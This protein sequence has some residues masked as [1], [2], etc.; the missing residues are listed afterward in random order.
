MKIIIGGDL[1]VNMQNISLFE[2]KGDVLSGKLKNIWEKAD[3]RIFNLESP[4]T[5]NTQGILKSGP[6]LKIETMCYTGIK[7]LK[8]NLMALANNHIMDYGEKGL[9]DTLKLLKK[10]KID[11]VGVGSD[12]Q[13]LKKYIFLEYGQEKIAIYNCA[14]TEFTIASDTQAGANPYHD[15]FTNKDISELKKQCQKLIVIYHGGKEC[16]RYPSPK[17]Q[18]RCRIMAESGADY[19]FCQHS[20]CIG[21]EEKYK[22]SVIVY[23]QG[24]FFFQPKN[25]AAEEM[26]STSLLIAID[27]LS[28]TKALTYIPIKQNLL[29]RGG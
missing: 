20:H 7:S 19:V 10:D 23:G 3:F 16:Y 24:N 2:K 28:K 25:K 18:E 12:I 8:P 4:I 21:C 1:V 13:H 15:Y 22:K 14:E 5:D 17:L 29:L 26:F 27:T 6:L 9:S 11:Y